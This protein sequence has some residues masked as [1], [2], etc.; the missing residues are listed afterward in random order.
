MDNKTVS[1]VGFEVKMTRLVQP[2]LMMYYVPC[3]AIVLVS[4]LGFVVSLTADGSSSLLVTNLL[5]LVSL[6]IYQMVRMMKNVYAFSWLFT[7][8][9]HVLLYCNIMVSKL[10]FNIAT[11]E[12]VN[13]RISVSY[14][15]TQVYFLVVFV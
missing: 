2:Y 11:Q 8:F 1:T 13:M 6:F 5:T 14:C 9:I 15:N 7:I 4:E 3:I 12:D 10:R